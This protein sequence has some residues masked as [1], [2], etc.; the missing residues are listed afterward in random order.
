MSGRFS[1]LVSSSN[2]PSIHRES[3]GVKPEARPL[4][5]L[6]LRSFLTSVVFGPQVVLEHKSSRWMYP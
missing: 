2:F 4:R 5:V 3:E 6:F 1:R